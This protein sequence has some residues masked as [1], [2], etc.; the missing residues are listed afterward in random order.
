MTTP[1]STAPPQRLAGLSALSGVNEVL[2]C[3]VFGVL[4]NGEWSFPA[5][6]D[7]LVH[8]R[9]AGGSVVLL[10]NSPRPH[11]SVA[12][13]LASLGVA[14]AAWDAIVTSGDVTRALIE[15]ADGP[16]WHLGPP[17]DHGLY[18]GLTVERT[19]LEDA[20]TIV[21]T[22]LF[23]D[24]REQPEDYRK[25]FET[26]VARS[27]PMICAN[28]D[29][30]V[31]RGERMVWCAGALARLYAELGGEVRMAGKPF[32]PIYDLA[33]Q[34]ASQVRGKPV[35]AADAMAI[36][37]GMPTDVRGAIDNGVP[38]LFITGGIHEAEYGDDE[39]ALRAFLHSENVSPRY[40][41]KALQWDAP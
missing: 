31:E 3:D 6:A 16:V 30:V 13:Q 25:L 41:A 14:E 23:D 11:G 12:D 37:D 18:E 5:A 39:Q 7:A 22:G 36:G 2:L 10:T 20:R 19:I 24:E 26:A 38:L 35:A 21:C 28:P 34:R 1:V 17:R 15:Q 27:L 32:A 40:F 8:F 29:I 9:Q 4:H 33:L